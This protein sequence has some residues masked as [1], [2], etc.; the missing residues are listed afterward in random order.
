M[1]GAEKKVWQWAWSSGWCTDAAKRRLSR[2]CICNCLLLF[3]IAIFLS[4]A[5]GLAQSGRPEKP[6]QG[7]IRISLAGEVFQGKAWSASIGEG[8]TL[9]LIPVSGIAPDGTAYSGWDL[10]AN[11]ADSAGY[12]DALLLATPPYG[13]LN[14]REIATT[15]GMRAQD[16]IAWEPRRFRFLT[17]QPDVLRARALYE[18]LMSTREKS[19]SDRS[20]ASE[21]LL[22]LLRSAQ[23][24]SGQLRI[25]DAHIVPGIADPPPFAQGWAQHLQ[26]VPHR[27]EQSVAPTPRGQLRWMRFSV[28]L[29]L[30]RRW[31]APQGLHGVPA[32]CAE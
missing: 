19:S 21:Q 2:N 6:D 14:S 12:P 28:D 22:V 26:L 7:C 9:R 8:W 13:S 23:Q 4:S 3:A 17:A 11:R 18:R 27:D 29:W 32:K 16:A 10:A 15:Y 1:T 25:E 31:I 30:P 5:R 24:G 20:E